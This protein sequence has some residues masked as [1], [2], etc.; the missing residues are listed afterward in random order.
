MT[1]YLISD[2]SKPWIALFSSSNLEAVAEAIVAQSQI[3]AS[4]IY[5]ALDGKPRSLNAGER[6][7]LFERVLEL[8]PGDQLAVGELAAAKEQINADGHR[9]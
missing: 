2:P 7:E 1:F 4:S 5:A 3:E 9:R 6:T 8:R